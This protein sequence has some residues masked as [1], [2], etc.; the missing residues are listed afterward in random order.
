MFMHH[1]LVSILIKSHETS[2]HFNTLIKHSPE[3][4]ALFL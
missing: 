3:Q 1:A 2:L 4:D